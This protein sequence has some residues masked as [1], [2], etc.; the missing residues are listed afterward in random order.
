MK[1]FLMMILGLHIISGEKVMS[2]DKTVNVLMKTSLGEVEIELNQEKAPISVKNFLAYVDDKYYDGTVFHRVI[3]NFMIQGGGFTPDME[4]KK[5]KA[6]IKNEADNGLKNSVGTLAM[7][8]TMV[9]DSATSQF[10]I[11]V[12]DNSSLD[13]QDK[14]SNGFGYAVFGKVVKGMDVVEKIK[15][16]PT[17]TKGP[18]RDVPA[19]AV[20]IESIRRK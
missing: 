14:S 18:H 7:A 10:F 15:A 8:R 3:S 5:T 20:V 4:Q 19:T 2:A 9:V 6:S 11:N 12:R 1:I 17:T 16:V 13:H